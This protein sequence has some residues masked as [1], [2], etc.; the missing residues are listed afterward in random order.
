[1]ARRRVLWADDQ[2]DVAQSLSRVLHPLDVTIEYVAD[3]EEALSRLDAGQVYDCLIVDLSMPPGNWGGLWLLEQLSSRNHTPALVLSGEGSQRETIAAM[4][5]GAVDYVL[6]EDASE[7]LPA[8][9][10][11][12]FDSAAVARQRDCPV[13]ELLGPPPR[14]SPTLEYKST[15]RVRAGG[16]SAGEVFKPLESAA[17]KTVDAFL[18]S[19]T[20]GTLLIGVR[21]DGTVA[22][23]EPDFASLRKPGKDDAD[24]F[25]L[26]IHQAVINA[27]GE[28]AAVNVHA[29][30]VRIRDASVC[31]VHVE[32]SKFPVS[33]S[34]TF[35]SNGQHEKRTGHY[36]RF[37]NRTQ[38]VTD[39]AE[40]AQLER[41]IWG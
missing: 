15:F 28:A 12:V 23:L 4:R 37:G 17:L 32:P 35:V 8:Q 21:D 33:A 24:L 19:R 25:L 3:G 18:N 13:E 11:T 39:E 1:M 14:E 27:V 16:D 9:L 20:G 5:M 31:R 36:F 6:K 7:E 34:L 22:G 40:L 29:E 38:L 26:H 10:Q 2:L 41:Q 30:V